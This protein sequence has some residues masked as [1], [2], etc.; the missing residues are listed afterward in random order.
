MQYQLRFFDRRHHLADRFDFAAPDD[1]EAAA[2]AG[3]MSEGQEMELWS[4]DRCLLTWAPS[5]NGQPP[6]GG[7]FRGLLRRNRTA[8][9]REFAFRRR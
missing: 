8:T 5:P 9:A 1:S 2:A 7:L 4:G 3:L 6:S